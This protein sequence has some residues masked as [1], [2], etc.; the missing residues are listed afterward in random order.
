[1]R[2]LIYLAGG[3]MVTGI[4]ISTMPWPLVIGSVFLISLIH[5]AVMLTMTGLGLCRE[6]DLKMVWW[7]IW[8]VV[9]IQF[10]MVL[11]PHRR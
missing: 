8:V 4:I 11:F 9:S 6:N 10:L 7:N 5:I 1:M 3:G 2:D